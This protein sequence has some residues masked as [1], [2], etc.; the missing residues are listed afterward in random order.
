[1]GQGINQNVAAFQQQQDLEK[2]RQ[3]YAALGAGQGNPFQGGQDPAF[4]GRGFDAAGNP[5][6]AASGSQPIAP[7]AGH[8]QYVK[9]AG[10][11]ALLNSV[12]KPSGAGGGSA[13]SK[14]AALKAL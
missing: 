14:W 13:L 3:F 9:N 12:I 6:G 8:Q 10:V 7:P 2:L 11:N 4:G 5:L 1:M